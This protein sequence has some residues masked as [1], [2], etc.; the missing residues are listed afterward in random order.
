MY[1]V[2][3]ERTYPQKLAFVYLK[4]LAE[5]FQDELKSTYGTSGGVDYLSR[6]ETIESSYSFIKFGTHLM[7]TDNSE[8]V[9]A[10]KKKEFRDSNAKENVDKLN[11]ELV[12][13]KNIMHENFDMILNRDRNLSKISQMSSDL[14]D[15]SKKVRS[16][17]ALSGLVQERCKE[18]KVDNVAEAVCDVD[19]N[20]SASSVYLVRETVCVLRVCLCIYQ[21][22]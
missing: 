1:L 3:A 15:N 12:D 4:D 21:L 22:I 13:I 5:S 7:I 20:G 17:S 6:I 16:L 9:I 19:R 11:Q 14:K 2:I 10:R 18:V 8:K